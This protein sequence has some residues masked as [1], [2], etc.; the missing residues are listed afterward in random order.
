MWNMGMSSSSIID[1]SDLRYS[2]AMPAI[3]I[4]LELCENTVPN[5]SPL[6][7]LLSKDI[8]TVL[9]AWFWSFIWFIYQLDAS[10]LRFIILTSVRMPSTCCRYQSGNVSLSPL[11]NSIALGAHDCSMLYAKSW[12]RYCFERSWSSQFW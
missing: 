11:V 5:L 7:V 1:E 4:L 10:R 9:L 6:Y 12:G 3:V 2:N 8:N